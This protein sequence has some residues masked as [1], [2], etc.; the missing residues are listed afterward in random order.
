VDVTTGDVAAA[1]GVAKATLYANFKDKD[2]LIEAVISRES[3]HVVADDLI[4][5]QPGTTFGQVLRNFGVQ[6]VRF[7]NQTDI[8]GW[9]RLIAHGSKCM[10]ELRLRFYDAGPGRW[11]R[12]LA[13]LLG[14]GVERGR[15][16]PLNDTQAA[17]DLSA[18]WM[19]STSLE[20]KLGVR[21][22]L[23]D[24]NLL[25]KVDHGIDVF[26]AFTGQLNTERVSDL[27]HK[28][29]PSFYPHPRIGGSVRIA[30]AGSHA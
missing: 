11:N 24:E 15:L 3:E 28:T 6:Y 2:E 13:Q 17:E 18:L 7:V 4:Q 22:P 16:R 8:A 27:R 5:V 19:G 10:P 30:S 26:S 25:A 21:Q 9:D 23:D 12:L 29:R 20:V 1:A 14:N